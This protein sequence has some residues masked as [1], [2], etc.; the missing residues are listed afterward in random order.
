MTFNVKDQRKRLH[1]NKRNNKKN[2]RNRKA[3]PKKKINLFTVYPSAGDS[4]RTGGTGGSGIALVAA[5][6]CELEL[7]A[8]TA[9][10]G[11][12]IGR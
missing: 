1:V 9:W 2:T 10:A 7:R 8:C 4:Y 5:R 12:T 3:W 11:R 6:Y